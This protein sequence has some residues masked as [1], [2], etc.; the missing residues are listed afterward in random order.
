MGVC[1]IYLWVDRPINVTQKFTD[2]FL[3]FML[4]K[5]HVFNYC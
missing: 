1:S 4:N 2:I 3:I 5:K